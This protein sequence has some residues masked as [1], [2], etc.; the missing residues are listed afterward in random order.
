MGFFEICP[1]I[2]AWHAW[3]LAAGTA[4]A[5]LTS[6]LI[7]HQVTHFVRVIASQSNRHCIDFV[8]QV[9]PSNHCTWST[10]AYRL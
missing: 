2:S 4:F 8:Y 6:S 9:F 3:L 5:A 1:I 10:D 7:Y